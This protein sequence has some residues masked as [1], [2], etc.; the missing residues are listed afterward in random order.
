MGG[1]ETSMVVE[2]AHRRC[3]KYSLVL[4]AQAM[5]L[6]SIFLFDSAVRCHLFWLAQLGGLSI[7]VSG[8]TAGFHRDFHRW[9]IQARGSEQGVTHGPGCMSSEVATPCEKRA[10]AKQQHAYSVGLLIFALGALIISYYKW[11]MELLPLEQLFEVW[12]VVVPM[13]SIMHPAAHGLL[14]L[15]H[16]T[17]IYQST[18]GSV[19]IAC[20]SQVALAIGVLNLAAYSSPDLPA[21][22][23]AVVHRAIMYQCVFFCGAWYFGVQRTQEVKKQVRSEWEFKELHAERLESLDREKQRLDYERAL[24]EHRLEQAV[25]SN[26]RHNMYSYGSEGYAP[27]CMTDSEIVTHLHSP[28]TGGNELGKQPSVPL[29]RPLG[30][31]A[32]DFRGD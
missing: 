26:G 32:A 13:Y 10:T 2:E 17:Q 29:R 1:F 14:G 27:S 22:T 19:C 23:A 8:L 5:L 9:L 16:G 30:L 25:L 15:Y 4:H 28:P 24:A 6:A 31:R 12:E 20:I 11:A 18:L 3:K 7:F 21:R